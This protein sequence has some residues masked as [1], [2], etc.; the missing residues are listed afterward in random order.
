[1]R[2]QFCKLFVH[3]FLGMFILFSTAACR[4]EPPPPPKPIRAIKTITVAEQASGKMRQFSGVVEAADSSSIS[5]VLRLP[6]TFRK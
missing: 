4:E 5:F 2:N 1:M 3:A 6:A